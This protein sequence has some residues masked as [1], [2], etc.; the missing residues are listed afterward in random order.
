MKTKA[1]FDDDDFDKIPVKNR[2][3]YLLFKRV[4][5]AEQPMTTY[6]L[7]KYGRTLDMCAP[8]GMN[9]NTIRRLVESWAGQGLIEM[10]P[11]FRGANIDHLEKTQRGVDKLNWLRRL[12]DDPG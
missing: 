4:I 10:K 11:P 6:E 5:L 9:Y 8:F 12:F 1:N 7:M 3:Q 2:C